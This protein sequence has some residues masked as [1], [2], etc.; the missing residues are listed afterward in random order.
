[1]VK[2][3]LHLTKIP[4]LPVVVIK[5]T[6]RCLRVADALGYLTQVCTATLPSS[7]LAFWK[8]CPS[9]RFHEWSPA[10]EWHKA[11]PAIRLHISSARPSFRKV[12]FRS[13]LSKRESA[14]VPCNL[15]IQ[16]PPHDSPEVGAI[17]EAPT[18]PRLWELQQIPEWCTLPGWHK[19]VSV[20]EGHVSTSADSLLEICFCV[21]FFLEE[22]K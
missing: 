8:S 2:W 19:A 14:D 1:M 22:I 21:L 15:P 6:K 16:T 3:S 4:S 20:Q 10:P 12:I 17:L 7:H 5:W 9:E 11:A 13:R 18:I